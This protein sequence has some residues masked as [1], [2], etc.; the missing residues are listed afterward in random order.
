MNGNPVEFGGIVVGRIAHGQL[1]E[2]W[3]YLQAP[4]LVH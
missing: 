4:H 1:V 3:A 2:R